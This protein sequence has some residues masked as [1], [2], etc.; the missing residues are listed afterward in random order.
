[1]ITLLKSSLRATVKK[2][3]YLNRLWKQDLSLRRLKT[4]ASENTP[5]MCTACTG[6]YMGGGVYFLCCF[7]F[8]LF[9]DRVSMLPRLAPNSL[10]QKIL[11]PQ[12]PELLGVHTCTIMPSFYLVMLNNQ[13]W[14]GIEL[15]HGRACARQTQGPWF[16]PSSKQL[17]NQPAAQHP[18]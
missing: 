9:P 7:G 8:C 5:S 11:L 3:Q 6:L 14:P 15:S 17:A 1:L 13:Q 16:N 4:E 10:P 12:L 2:F 18:V